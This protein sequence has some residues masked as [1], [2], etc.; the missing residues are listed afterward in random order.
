MKI[1]LFHTVVVPLTP[2]STEPESPNCS[3][4]FLQLSNLEPIQ[5]LDPTT[6]TGLRSSRLFP[7]RLLQLLQTFPVSDGARDPT[8]SLGLPNVGIGVQPITI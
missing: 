6:A 8:L 5:N 7:F 3:R 2:L 4:T 1:I